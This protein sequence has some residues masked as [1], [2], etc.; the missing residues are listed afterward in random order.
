MTD[1]CLDVGVLG[2]LDRLAVVKSL[3]ECEIVRLFL[4]QVS[5]FPEDV[6]AILQISTQHT[7]C[8]VLASD[9]FGARYAAKWL[10]GGLR[11][12]LAGSFLQG[13]SK[14]LRAAWIAKSMSSASPSATW[15]ISLP[16]LQP[17]QVS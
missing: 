5:K 12:T 10:S 3:D 6:G 4:Y 14:A 13:P 2:D 9:G 7:R 11:R 16:V 1:G 8:V 17:R 15:Q